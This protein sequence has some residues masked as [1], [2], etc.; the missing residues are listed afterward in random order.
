MERKFGVN[1]SDASSEASIDSRGN[2]YLGKTI[3]WSTL[4]ESQRV[5]LVAEAGAGKTHECDAQA[6]DLFQRGEAAFFLRLEAVAAN[7]IRS[8][9][10]GEGLKK[11][12]DEWRASSS[13]VGYFFFDSIDELQLT[14]GDFRNALKRVHEDMEGALGRATV[15]VTS[16]PVDID[17]RAFAD[18]L[19]VPQTAI[20]ERHGESFVRM[21]L[22]GPTDEDKRRSPPFREVTL[23]SFSDE[24]IVEFARGQGVTNPDHLLAEIRARH[25]EDFARRPQ[26][27]IEL[28][29]SW[30]DFGKIRS[31]C[32]QLKSHIK[33]RLRARPKR[34]EPA[35]LTLNKA[36]IG[37][38]RLALA[39]MLGRRLTI[40]CSAGADVEGSGDAPLVPDDLLSD[41]TPS[42]M[43][44][45]LQRPIFVEGGYGRVRF[46]HRSV[47]EYLAATEIDHLV[48]SG[49][50]AV[51]AAK[52]MLFSLSDTEA[53]LPKPSMRPVAG[54]LA[55][56]R[57]EIFDTVLK[58]EPS[59]LLLYG[60]P[61]AL[62]DDQCAQALRAYVQLH[63]AGQWR[64]LEMPALQ[65]ERLA[66]KPLH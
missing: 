3:G 30:R 66:R 38:Q 53:L 21:A 14:H 56:M 22:Q 26:D 63:G 28:C 46:H 43:D 40:R 42:E 39:A 41:F 61:E 24:E 23:L 59:T 58:V 54:W 55:K 44:T 64:G 34:K 52:R 17:R 29:D 45:L 1:A 5:L 65:L 51:S 13:Q 2:V 25:A 57:P 32:D 7:G 16:R 36:R 4:L 37:V 12:F 11:R 62:S 48:S 47:L 20:E 6:E 19:P 33:A 27:L 8:S 35:E 60:D 50:L 49:A 10:F 15:V 18:V 31:H 9:L